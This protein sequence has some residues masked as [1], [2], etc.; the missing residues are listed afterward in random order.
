[1][2]ER[3]SAILS[4]DVLPKIADCFSAIQGLIWITCNPVDL[5]WRG[6]YKRDRPANIN[7]VNEKSI[8]LMN[9]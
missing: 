1:M 8:I 2:E 5:N 3:T 4:M 6:N 9:A 7:I